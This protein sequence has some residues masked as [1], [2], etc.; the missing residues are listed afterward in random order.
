MSSTF[1]FSKR[2][3]FVALILC[4]CAAIGLALEHLA[5]IDRKRLLPGAAIAGAGLLLYVRDRCFRVQGVRR[6]AVPFAGR[7]SA[8]ARQA[9]K[10][11]KAE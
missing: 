5:G 11:G 7:P 4:A 9:A 6:I 8:A 2:D 3:A 1:R 10:G